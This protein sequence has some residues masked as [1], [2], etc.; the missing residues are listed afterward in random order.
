MRTTGVAFTA[1]SMRKYF[2]S[3]VIALCSIVANCQHS[4]ELYNNG[5]IIRVTAGAEVH[6][7]GDVHMIGGT[8]TNDGL[9]KT[10]GNSYSNNTFQQR[11]TGTYR[12]ENAAVNTGERQFISGSFAVRGG[13]AQTGVDDGSFYNLELNNDQGVVY[14]VGTGDVAD[15]RGSVNFDAAG[16]GINNATSII[17]HDVGLTGAI[18]YPANGSLY[19]AQF[20]MMNPTAGLG[21]Y[22]NDT[23]HQNGNDNMS[24]VDRGYIIGKHRRALAPAG[25]T[26]GYPFGLEPA[27]GT[28]KR[29]FQYIHLAVAANDYDVISGYFETGS[30]NTVPP[31]SVPECS[32][33]EISYFGGVDHG[34]WMFNDITGTGTGDYTVQV[35]PQ[36]NT[37]TGGLVWLITK[38]NAIA[39][40]AN[41]CDVTPIGLER[42]FYQF[43]TEFSVASGFVQLPIELLE[44][45]AEGVIDHIEVSWR[46][47]SELELSHYVLER[48]ED[49][50]QF[51]PIAAIP[52]AGNTNQEQEYIYLDD[53]V[54]FNQNY[55]YRLIS[56]DIDGTEDYS[57]VVVASI[58][59]ALD[60]G[61]DI[62]LYPNPA[63]DN[64]N[65]LI[66]TTKDRNA[67]LRVTN[68]LGQLLVS[69]KG[70]LQSGNTVSIVEASAWS[71]GIY[72]V[73]L[74]DLETD[75]KIIK[76]I[77][78]Q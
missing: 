23:W 49:G 26:Y 31:G 9:I 17:T 39:G 7:V 2:F 10:H 28:D 20:G 46:V 59:N 33:Y 48:S 34:E 24:S 74:R 67:G 41:D 44:L 36:D 37:F 29:G 68:A 14:L 43:G 55:Y 18:T 76:K 66:T 70:A 19:D 16:L 61:M 57:P 22:L 69:E 56:V 8:L 15:V 30:D 45:R 75:E 1:N 42:D 27:G 62:Q 21:N 25:G 12:I 35:W 71:K 11:G 53:S 77:V 47:A 13:Q 58:E 73:E 64:F 5:A 52:G 78:I 32:G 6:V 72:F 3:F 65:I 51:T 4:H 38:D 63:E 54:R 40:L 50:Q 60:S